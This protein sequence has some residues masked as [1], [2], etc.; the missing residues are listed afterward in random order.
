MKKELKEAAKAGFTLVELLV[1]VAILG[2][3][4]AVAVT[5]LMGA[6]DETKVT[7]TRQTMQTIQSAL[8][9]QTET[10]GKKLPTSQEAF[11]SL[12]TDGD[13]DNPPAIE[14]GRDALNDAWGNRIQYKKTGKRFLLTSFGPDGEEGTEDDLFN[15]E[16]K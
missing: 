1:V 15:R 7:A 4:G 11:E 9:I 14:G 12:L 2:I 3:L 5:N 10:R 16:K 8:V 6:T 13:D